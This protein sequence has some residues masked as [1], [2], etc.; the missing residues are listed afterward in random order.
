MYGKGIKLC[1]FGGQMH[2]W[3]ASLTRHSI[4]SVQYSICA[5]MKVVSARNEKLTV[6]NYYMY[7]TD[8]RHKLDSRVK[9]ARRVGLTSNLTRQSVDHIHPRNL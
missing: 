3:P 9:H 4:T 6:R 1:A 7:Y 8:E 5:L 2:E